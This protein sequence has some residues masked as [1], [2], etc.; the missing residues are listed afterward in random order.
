MD[1]IKGL[2]DDGFRKDDY[3]SCFFFPL[4]CIWRYLHGKGRFGWA[5]IPFRDYRVTRH[6]LEFGEGVHRL[7]DTS[8]SVLS[9]GIFSSRDDLNLLWVSL[10]VMEPHLREESMRIKW[11]STL[12]A[13]R[14]QHICLSSQANIFNGRSYHTS[15]AHR[16]P[17]SLTVQ[18]LSSQNNSV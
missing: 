13:N 17:L 18:V 9:R 6:I 1:R 16:I 3:W 10:N 7:L 4:F 11:H 5:K 14:R 2:R 8:S 15:S 12:F